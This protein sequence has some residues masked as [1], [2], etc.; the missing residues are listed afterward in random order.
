MKDS[1][2]DRGIGKNNMS[3]DS[4]GGIINLI[5]VGHMCEI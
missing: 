3:P 4:D 5:K 1:K 2:T